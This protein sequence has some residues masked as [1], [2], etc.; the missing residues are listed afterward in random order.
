V[1]SV[2]DARAT[3]CHVCGVTY[4]V[5]EYKAHSALTAHIVVIKEKERK[6]VSRA[7]KAYRARIGKV[8]Y[9]SR[10][11][12]PA[13]AQPPEGLDAIRLREAMEDVMDKDIE[14]DLAAAVAAAYAAQSPGGEPA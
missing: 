3:Y 7:R 5:G 9:W 6:R 2:A 13:L 4:R 14:P 11:K 10:Q 1:A 12:P 8:S